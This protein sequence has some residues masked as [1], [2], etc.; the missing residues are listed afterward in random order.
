MLERVQ[1]AERFHAVGLE[2]EFTGEL[3]AHRHTAAM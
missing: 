1:I 3:E 2:A